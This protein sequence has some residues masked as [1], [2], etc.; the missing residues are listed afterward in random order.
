MTKITSFQSNPFSSINKEPVWQEKCCLLFSNISFRSR[1]IQVFKICKLAN[2]W[3]HILNQILIKYDEKRYLSQFSSE[4]FDSLQSD[5]NK[6]ASQFQLKQF[7][8]HGNILGSRPP[9]YKRCFWPPLAFHFHICKWCLICMIQRGYRYVS[10]SFWPPLTF[11]ELN[12]A[13][14]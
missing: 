4:M 3:R 12:I 6:C 1:D 10:S 14:I 5:S 8:Y 9:H 13:K 7:C 2:W 11:F